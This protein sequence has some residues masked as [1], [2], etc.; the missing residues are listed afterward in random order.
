M[1]QDKAVIVKID[2][3]MHPEDYIKRQLSKQDAE[4]KNRID[5]A[6]EQKKIVEKARLAA[7]EKT[8]LQTQVFSN[9][10]TELFDS[11]DTGMLK[12]DVVQ[13]LQDAGTIK[14]SSGATLKLKSTIKK[15]LVGYELKT[16]SERYFI[17]KVSS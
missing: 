1:S 14:S 9:L 7:N 17:K 12:K 2:L 4:T 8:R 16:D 15:E 13:R 3:T 10:F 5:K 6:I 11:G